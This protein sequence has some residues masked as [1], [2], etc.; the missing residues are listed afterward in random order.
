[1]M[2]MAPGAALAQSAR[3]AGGSVSVP[4]K[5]VGAVRE[6]Q[7]FPR[8]AGSVLAGGSVAAFDEMTLVTAPLQ[9][10]AGRTDRRNNALFLP[11]DPKT[12]EGRRTRLVYV[13][14]QDR[15]PLEVVRNYQQFVRDAG[16]AAV[17]ECAGDDCGGDTRLGA[18]SGGNRTGVLQLMLPGDDLPA[19][20]DPLNCVGDN[21]SRSGQRY[22]LMTLANDGGHVAVLSYV[23]GDYVAGSSCHQWK[24]RTVAIVNIVETKAREQR[25]EIVRADAMGGSMARD[26][27]V[28]FYSIL[29]DTARAEIKP[30]SEPQIAEMAAYLRANPGLRVLIVGH[31]DSQGGLDYN[32]DLSRRRAASVIGALAARGIQAS[33]LTPQ[34][35]GMAAPVS[36]NDTDDGR[37]RNRR[38]EMVKM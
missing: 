21:S 12:V 8:Y 18:T 5:D 15:S 28:T 11:P 32:V 19:R 6:P 7:G 2:M 30:E 29:F 9:R 27:K 16:G 23:L 24:G 22:A 20:G 33:R 13:I 1:M 37:A 31:T 10:V 35:V 4:V 34:G 14:P 38:V 17:F 25:M 3:P 26:G 36:T